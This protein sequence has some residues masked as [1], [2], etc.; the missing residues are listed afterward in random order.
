MLS[1]LEVSCTTLDSPKSAILISPL[2][3]NKLLGL[4]SKWM[5]LRPF[6]F[7]YLKPLS[8]WI[9][10]PWL[11]AEGGGATR[12]AVN[13]GGDGKLVGSPN[14]GAPELWPGWA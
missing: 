6:T 11:R 2:W 10:M 8:T 5:I 1:L 13:Q 7:M 12:P 9:T 4:R 14:M 3:K